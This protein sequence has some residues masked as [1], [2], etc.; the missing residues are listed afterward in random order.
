[1]A[2]GVPWRQYYHPPSDIIRQRPRPPPP[3]LCGGAR[4]RR[5]YDLRDLRGA[6]IYRV[7]VE[8]WK[9]ERNVDTP[10]SL[11]IC[12]SKDGK[13][14]ELSIY[15]Y[16][17][18]FDDSGAYELDH[19]VETADCGTCPLE[20]APVGGD[21]ER[22]RGATIARVVH[23]GY[24]SMAD[25]YFVRNGSCFDLHVEVNDMEDPAYLEFELRRAEPDDCRGLAQL[26]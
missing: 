2:M 6:R 25:V 26:L 3:P 24:L 10:R 8:T 22:L 7:S 17:M 1:M 4:E 20:W 14:Y 15:V 19:Y 23:H 11:V 18:W 9:E 13:Y 5:E 16:W 12:A 21:L